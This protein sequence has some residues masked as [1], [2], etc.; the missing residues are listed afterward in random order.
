MKGSPAR[1]GIRA[2][3]V[4]VALLLLLPAA[5]A[6]AGETRT[7]NVVLSF[8]V[9]TPVFSTEVAFG[10]PR[11]ALDLPKTLPAVVSLRADVNLYNFVQGRPTDSDPA[12]A[13]Y[14]APQNSNQLFNEGTRVKYAYYN[15]DGNRAYRLYGS[16][17]G[18]E[19]AWYACDDYG[20]QILGAVIDLPVLWRGAYYG[21][22]PGTYLQEVELDTWVFA[23]ALP[24]GLIVVTNALPS[25]PPTAV[26]SP[27]P[28][29]APAPTPDATHSGQSDT[30]SPTVSAQTA[31]PTR[32]L[33]ATRPP[34]G[35]ADSFEFAEPF[36]E[37][38][39]WVESH[40]AILA[41][42]FIFL[43]GSAVAVIIICVFAAKRRRKKRRW[44]EQK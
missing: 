6:R 40:W 28:S 1:G 31:K 22:R 42:A 11:D 26:P 33:R 39:S 3:A 15:A 21:D 7:G 29:T 44:W 10:T 24:F 37:G 43:T 25:V 35:Q 13:R 14:V 17:D 32:Q 18:G 36:S 5:L 23:N 20:Q 27:I 2:L 30:A 34:A 9:V 41:G 19:N 38:M 4:A 16:L 12:L 8:E